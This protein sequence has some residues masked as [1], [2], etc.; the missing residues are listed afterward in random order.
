M[1]DI[2]STPCWRKVIL[3]MEISDGSAQMEPVVIVGGGPA[4]MMLGYQLACAGIATCVLEKHADFLR[5]F[6]GDTV[7]PSTLEILQQLDLLQ[8]FEKLPQQRVQQL[9][10]RMGEKLQ[11]VIDLRGLQPFDFLA[12]VPQWDLLD[13]I[14]DKAAP[15]AHFDLRMRHEA[16]E[17]LI[18]TGRVRGVRVRSPEGEGVL[19]GRLVIACDGRGSSMRA[20]AGLHATD[21]GAPMDVLW[22]R[23]PR[24]AQASD[25]T[26]AIVGSG[27]MMVLLNR[28]AYW[29]A[30]YVVPKGSD[31]A[32]RARPIDH[33]HEAIVKLAPFLAE[34]VQ[35]VKAWDSVKTL[36]VHVD[37]LDCWHRP[38]LLLIG[39][40]AHAMSP[41]GGVG[42]N[43][44]VQDAVAAANVLI[45][46]L[47][48][49]ANLDDAVLDKVRQRRIGP[50]KLIQKLQVVIQKRLIS[51]ILRTSGTPPSMPL[52][53][54]CLL[55]FRVIRNIP[56]RVIGYGWRREHVQWKDCDK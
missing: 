31:K 39:D 20:A 50:V 19:H 35:A 32:M 8:G 13:Y 6:R 41:I 14:A 4:G 17:L 11:P 36:S 29:Q 48:A 1:P 33:L 54:R 53:L 42:I 47:R 37:R 22:F 2:L 51:R 56:A 55:R 24:D 3:K 15:F 23:L 10:V 26:F 27:Q 43:L 46:A 12:L 52:I 18:E 49:N 16:T 9:S 30:A 7:H 21:L 40:A 45:P 44:A 5:D 25:D 34:S 38:G 28:D